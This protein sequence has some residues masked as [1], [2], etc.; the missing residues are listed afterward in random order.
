MNLMDS[1]NSG[2]NSA[3]K[4]CKSGTEN[5]KIKAAISEQERIIEKMTEEIGNLVIIDLDNGTQLS[6]AVMERY[7]AIKAAREI[8]NEIKIDKPEVIKRV[9]PSCGKKSTGDMMYCGH[10]GSKLEIDTESAEDKDDTDDKPE[11]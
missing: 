10:C 8:I 1:L 3:M 2:V 5:I 9:C 7:E 4:A 6:P 11:E